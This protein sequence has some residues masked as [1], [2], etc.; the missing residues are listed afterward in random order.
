LKSADKE[1]SFHELTRIL[2]N[3]LHV[4][5]GTPLLIAYSG[6]LD[7]HVLLHALSQQGNWP[8]EAVH[9]HHGLLTE[10]DTWAEHCQSVC[11]AMAIPLRIEH[12]TVDRQSKSGLEAAARQARYARWREVLK[13]DTCLLTAH[14]QGDQAETLLLQLL[15]GG[16][17]AGLAAMAASSSFASGYLL[18]PLLGF[19]RQQLSRYA[20]SEGLSWIE[21]PSNQDRRYR[22]NIIRHE[23]LPRLEQSW[24]GTSA[25][26]ARSSRH[27]AEAL[28]VLEEVA[29]EDLRKCSGPEGALSIAGLLALSTDRSRNAMRFWWRLR[30]HSVPS[31]RRLNHLLQ[32]LAGS[33]SPHAVWRWGHSEMRR[34]RD[35]LQIMTP[36]Q[37]TDKFREWSWMPAQNPAIDVQHY[38]LSLRKTRGQGLAL[39][40]ME[41]PWRVRLR[42]GGEVC[43]LAG[44]QHHQKLKKLLQEAGIPPWQRE[45][46]PLVYIEDQ[47]AAV[48]SLWVC[49]PFA[50]QECEEAVS[51][52]VSALP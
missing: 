16:G 21:D 47:L 43:Q 42:R 6:G 24:P 32:E 39:H 41:S 9:V 22:R 17:V 14:H 10:A 13:P 5:P 50:A 45:R 38:H 31:S 19:A 1:F 36:L 49:E 28:R 51:V 18:R 3:V 23:V 7:S 34:Y 20:L 12:V 40:W 33:N 4:S 37:S 29:R 15:R 48:G 2:A 11:E 30:G 26:L 46:L 25:V 27:F 8:L 44:K 35:S 52:E